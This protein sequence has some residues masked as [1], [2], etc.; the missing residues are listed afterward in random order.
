MKMLH[1]ILPA[2][3][4]GAG[5]GKRLWRHWE[6]DLPLNYANA[7]SCSG[8]QGV[9]T[10]GED[11]SVFG[12][13]SYIFLQALVTYEGQIWSLLTI[14]MMLTSHVLYLYTQVGQPALYSQFHSS[15][16]SSS[17]NSFPPPVN[18][19]LAHHMHTH[20][21]KYKNSNCNRDSRAN[22]RNKLNQ[23][24]LY[25]EQGIW[26]LGREEEYKTIK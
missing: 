17:T 18:P 14:N 25:I 11:F 16:P 6:G 8:R 15:S 19:I 7:A 22:E 12:F 24:Q 3:R 20:I 10:W 5:M 21:H 1:L 23:K 2:M 9:D 26:W 13:R 4:R